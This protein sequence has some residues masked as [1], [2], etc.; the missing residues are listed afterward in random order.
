MAECSVC[1]A[2]VFWAFTVDGRAVGMDVGP[3]DDG[4]L[5]LDSSGVVERGRPLSV[6][7]R[8]GRAFREHRCEREDAA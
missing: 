1:G 4:D 2:K 7:E 5:V 6:R 3:R 8:R